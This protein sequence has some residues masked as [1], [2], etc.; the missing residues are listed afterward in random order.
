MQGPAF[1]RFVGG[2][3]LVLGIWLTLAPAMWNYGVAGD[4]FDAQ[5][6]DVLVG[7]AVLLS[8]L[9]RMARPVRS[10]TVSMISFMLGSWLVVAPLALAY[11]F[12]EDSTLATVNDIIVGAVIAVSSIFG[13]QR[14]A[15]SEG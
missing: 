11:G 10:V 12:D 7:I 6:N 8:G 15:N 1:T 2:V 5:W 13:H 14:A 9:I 3:M 4:G